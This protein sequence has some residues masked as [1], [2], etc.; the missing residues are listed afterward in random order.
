MYCTP[1]LNMR[2]KRT[3]VSS[4]PSQVHTRLT[5]RGATLEN[6]R[7]ASGW[8]TGS[9]TSVPYPYWACQQYLSLGFFKEMLGSLFCASRDGFPD[10]ERQWDFFSI[11]AENISAIENIF[12]LPLKW[13]LVF[14]NLEERKY[15][16]RIMTHISK[17]IFNKRVLGT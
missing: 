16:S 2:K 6:S 9:P 14:M 17:S 12:F 7:L 11:W 13:I 3:T 15:M 8:G 10:Y 5:H 4:A 1:E